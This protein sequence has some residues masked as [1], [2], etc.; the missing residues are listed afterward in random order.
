MVRALLDGRKTQTRRIVKGMALD[1][2]QP[3]MFSP[4]YVA[5]PGS[6]LSPYGFAGDQLYVRETF[7]AYGRWET[8]HNVKKGRDEWHFVD[9][10]LECDRIYQYVVDE[11]DVPLQWDRG[12]AQTGW[13]RRP[14]IFMHRAASRITLEVT[15]VCV[16]RL[17]D[18]SEE[19]ALAEGSVNTLNPR[20]WYAELWDSLNAAR[21][22]GWSVN[23][24]VWVVEFKRVEA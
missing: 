1:W 3:G 14:S 11:P 19:D 13:Y 24:W 9:M 15:N 22:S 16:E 7:F 18:I 21:G 4:G 8:R 6:L 2:L 20:S 10:T 12:G 17:Q 5:S 23:P